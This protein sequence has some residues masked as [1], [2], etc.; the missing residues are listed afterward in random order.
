[1][2]GYIAQSL[3]L[4]EKVTNWGDWIYYIGVGIGVIVVLIILIKVVNKYKGQGKNPAQKMEFQLGG[5]G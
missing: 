5:Q 1:M 4:T 2:E 3:T